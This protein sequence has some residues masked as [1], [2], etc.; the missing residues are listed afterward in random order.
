MLLQDDACTPQV[1]TR[2]RATLD[3]DRSC[4]ASASTASTPRTLGAAV[5]LALRSNTTAEAVPNVVAMVEPG[6]LAPQETHSTRDLAPADGRLA[7]SSDGATQQLTY[8]LV[9]CLG[10]ELR[11]SSFHVNALRLKASCGTGCIRPNS[12]PDD[13]SSARCMSACAI[14]PLNPNELTPATPSVKERPRSRGKT[15]H[16]ADAPNLWPTRGLRTRK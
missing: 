7:P 12:A 5:S 1:S 14:V 16:A 15:K 9:S 11:S 13:P 6:A 4:C 10:D 8:T 3:T 2:N